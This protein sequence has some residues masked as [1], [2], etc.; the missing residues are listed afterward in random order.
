LLDCRC[1]I[2]HGTAPIEGPTISVHLPLQR[3]RARDRM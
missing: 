1:C 2:V 3:V